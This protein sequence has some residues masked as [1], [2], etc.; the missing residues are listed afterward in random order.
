MATSERGT[1]PWLFLVVGVETKVP[2][3]TKLGSG[4]DATKDRDLDAGVVTRTCRML[5]FTRRP[6]RGF[7]EIGGRDNNNISTELNRR[8]SL[9]RSEGG[10]IIYYWDTTICPS[11]E[12]ERDTTSIWISL[13]YDWW[14]RS[15]AYI[16]YFSMQKI[17]GP[18]EIFF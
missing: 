11:K 4:D 15:Q 5:L 17:I 2:C 18:I 8:R 3:K 10:I 6:R 16:L 12:R 13:I 1:R 14:R 7:D 9:T